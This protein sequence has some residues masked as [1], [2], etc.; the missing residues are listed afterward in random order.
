[1]AHPDS[2]I[3]NRKHKHLSKYER[4][5][6]EAY[7]KEGWSFRA[8]GRSLGRPASTIKREVARGTVEQRDSNWKISKKYFPDTGQR[9]YEENRQK[10]GRK[11][12]YLVEASQTF[13]DWATGKMLNEKWSPDVCVGRAKVQSDG[14]VLIPST[15]SEEHTS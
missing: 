3:V 11:R 4:G 14:D 12:Q 8:M 1:M 7:R 2:S 9:V 15:R 13:L 10:C 5:Q 6:I